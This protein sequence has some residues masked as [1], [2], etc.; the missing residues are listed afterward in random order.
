MSKPTVQLYTDGA[1]LGNPGPGGYAALL[2]FDQNE[3]MVTGAEPETTNN[4]MELRAVIEGVRNLK[5][6]CR[7]DITTDS[8]YVSNGITQW[9][10]GWKKN[11]WKNAQKKPVKNQDLWKELDEALQPHEIHWHWV[12]GH[13]GHPENERVDEAARKV[14]EDKGYA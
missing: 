14:I 2:V 11:G 5:K 6:P 4:R 7:V 1:C 12:K 9:M 10:A 13:S 3:K 8:K